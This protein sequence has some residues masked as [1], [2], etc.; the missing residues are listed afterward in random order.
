MLLVVRNI[1]SHAETLTTLVT[2]KAQGYF[3][4]ELLHCAIGGPDITCPSFWSPEY[5]MLTIHLYRVGTDMEWLLAL[6]AGNSLWQH[7]LDSTSEY[8]CNRLTVYF[9]M[10]STLYIVP[11]CT[12]IIWMHQLFS[13]SML[14]IYSCKQSAHRYR[15]MWE[16]QICQLILLKC[17]SVYTA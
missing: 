7:D 6:I 14:V 4:S 1:H 13:W 2:G 10:I 5:F 16:S 17:P 8:V 12:V 15:Y 11:I 9:G 3:G